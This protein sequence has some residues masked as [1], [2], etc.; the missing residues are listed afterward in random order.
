MDRETHFLGMIQQTA[1]EDPMKHT[2]N[3]TF[4]VYSADSPG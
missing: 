1:K 4:S 2:L 3:A